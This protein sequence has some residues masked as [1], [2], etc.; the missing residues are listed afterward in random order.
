MPRRDCASL[1]E[2][3]KLNIWL[4]LEGDGGGD[5]LL[6]GGVNRSTR[7]LMGLKRGMESEEG[8]DG[9]DSTNVGDRL[10][11]HLPSLPLRKHRYHPM[12]IGPQLF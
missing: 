5:D 11:N 1:H 2:F 3:N 8:E 10:A 6:V 4:S 12:S 9:L 7:V